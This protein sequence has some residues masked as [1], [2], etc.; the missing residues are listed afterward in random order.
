MVKTDGVLVPGWALG[1]WLLWLSASVWWRGGGDLILSLKRVLI[2]PS[3]SALSPSQGPCFL[4]A[5]EL[6]P[7]QGGSRQAPAI[8]DFLI[9][10]QKCPN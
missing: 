10:R 6:R 9:G 1:R 3:P 7:V 4:F 5:D 2:S 8:A